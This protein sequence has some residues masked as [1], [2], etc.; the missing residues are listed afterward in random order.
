MEG[1]EFSKVRFDNWRKVEHYEIV[2]EFTGITIFRHLGEYPDLITGME[3]SSDVQKP[4]G[5]K[6]PKEPTE[7]ERAQH[8]L[9]HM[10]YAP[11]CQACVHGKGKSDLHQTSRST[12]PVV[13]MDFTFPQFTLAGGD[14]VI[15]TA[16]DTLT[17]MCVAIKL[18]SKKVS[19]YA[20]AEIRA[21]LMD[22][23]RTTEVI[24]Q[25]D[26]EPAILALVRK[27][28]SGL[29]NAEVRQSPTHSSGSQGAVERFH[30]TLFGHV[31]TL[32]IA[33]S[34]SMQ[35]LQSSTWS[36]SSMSLRTGANSICSAVK[37]V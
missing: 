11:W 1:A 16:V 9:T 29:L 33:L 4:V 5:L 7:S 34:S 28:A 25:T 21:F 19:D 14:V 31:R 30:Q 24:L 10:P 3:P 32:R 12:L 6:V 18:P 15:L 20:T 2:K 8:E 35:P 13:Q 26:Q 36:S 27:I 17:G 37:M 23:G 22:C